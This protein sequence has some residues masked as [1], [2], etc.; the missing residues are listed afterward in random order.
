MRRLDN[1]ED[2]SPQDL[3]TRMPRTIN[4]MTQAAF[5]ELRSPAPVA[6]PEE[7]E[8]ATTE[9]ATSGE[10][11]WP[12]EFP[13]NRDDLFTAGTESSPSTPSTIMPPGVEPVRHHA[14]TAATPAQSTQHGRAPARAPSPLPH[15]PYAEGYAIQFAALERDYPEY[16]KFARPLLARV[17]HRDP[18][19][20]AS[21]LAEFKLFARRTQDAIHA[22]AMQQRDEMIEKVRLEREAREAQEG[23]HV[24]YVRLGSG[25]EDENHRQYW[26]GKPRLT[27]EQ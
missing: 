26:D 12:E 11:D 24:R 5:A 2:T 22:A 15:N 1:R 6:A 8:Y 18:K 19:E 21:L 17:E 3:Y 25:D 14:T 20:A 10:E 16:Y 9:W 13:E 7:Y 4:D 23:N 27:V